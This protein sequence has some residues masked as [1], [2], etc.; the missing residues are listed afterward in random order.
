MNPNI[1]SEFELIILLPCYNSEQHIAETIN[2]GLCQTW[3]KKIIIVENGPTE[4][5]YE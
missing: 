3:Q 1:E 2:S 5:N 4:C